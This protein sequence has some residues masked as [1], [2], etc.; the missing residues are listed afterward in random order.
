MYLYVSVTL[1]LWFPHG[2]FWIYL[3]YFEREFWI[4]TSSV[5]G[6]YA[7]ICAKITQRDIRCEP[8]QNI[9]HIAYTFTHCAGHTANKTWAITPNGVRLWVC[10]HFYQIIINHFCFVCCCLFCLQVFQWSGINAIFVTFVVNSY[11]YTYFSKPTYGELGSRQTLASSDFFNSYPR[12]IVTILSF[13][14]MANL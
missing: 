4:V 12:I 13:S 11:Q 10:E 3:A 5:C 6:D 2:Y 8:L 14:L 7:T 9:I 1:L